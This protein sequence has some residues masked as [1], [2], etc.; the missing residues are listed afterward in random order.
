MGSLLTEWM[1]NVTDRLADKICEW[2]GLSPAP[3]RAACY[4]IIAVFI[5]EVLRCDEPMLENVRDDRPGTFR[6][7]RFAEFQKLW[8]QFHFLFSSSMPIASP[9]CA[10]N[11]V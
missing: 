3:S 8:R 7:D 1:K 11:V 10:D 6:I 2:A 4:E 5:F 9:H